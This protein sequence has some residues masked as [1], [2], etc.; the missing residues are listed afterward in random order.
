[1]CYLSIILPAYNEQIRLPDSIAKIHSFIQSVN[2]S[3]EVIIV[4]NGSTDNTFNMAKDFAIN[5][6]NF[7]VIEEKNKGK[8][9]AVKTGMLNAKGQYRIFSDVDLS[10]PITEIV[11]F[12]PPMNYSPISIASREASGAIRYNEPW[13]RHIM[14]RVF[15]LLVSKLLIPELKDTQCGFK[16]F[17]ADAA[18]AVFHNLTSGGWAFDIEILYVARLL[19]FQICEIPVSWYYHENSKISPVRDSIAMFK[20][21]FNIKQKYKHGIQS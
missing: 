18:D 2:Y 5:Y 17:R 7:H 20:E 4:D 11:N 13:N 21:V 16:C 19:N 9:N 1:M 3:T 15:N 6:P 10:V 8:G 14:G 12:L